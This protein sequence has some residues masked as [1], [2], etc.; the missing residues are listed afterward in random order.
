L[1]GI[2]GD[3]VYYVSARAGQIDKHSRNMPKFSATGQKKL[4]EYSILAATVKSGPFP[5]LLLA[6]K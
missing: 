1:F 2:A 6:A 5:P 4:L 3:D